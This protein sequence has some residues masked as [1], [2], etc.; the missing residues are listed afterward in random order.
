[1]SRVEAPRPRWV[2]E[3]RKFVRRGVLAHGFGRLRGRPLSVDV[4]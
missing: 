1:M 2:R 4:P 3:F